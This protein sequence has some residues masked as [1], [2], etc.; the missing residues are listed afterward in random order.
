MI[1][2]FMKVIGVFGSIFNDPPYINHLSQ[3]LMGKKSSEICGCQDKALHHELMFYLDV[4]IPS[5][6]KILHGQRKGPFREDV[7]V[8]GMWG[9]PKGDKV[10][11]PL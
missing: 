4:L 5:P 9:Q 3:G 8:Q 11:Q 6:Q 7:P 10:K 1:D 2:C